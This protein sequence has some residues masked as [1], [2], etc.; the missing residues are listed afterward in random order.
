I[1]DLA[2]QGKSIIM[3]SSEL[4]ELL[5]VSDKIMVMSN[6]RASGIVNTKDTSQEELMTLASKF[7]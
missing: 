5:G 7:V 2:N 6:G 1:I 3:V 4:P